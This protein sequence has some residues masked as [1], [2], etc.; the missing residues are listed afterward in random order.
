MQDNCCPIRI[1]TTQHEFENILGKK[2]RRDS[3]Q[4]AVEGY[5]ALL[6]KRNQAAPGLGGGKVG[7]NC[8]S[9]NF[10]GPTVFR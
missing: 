3:A 8:E 10:D 9:C 6:N 2:K 5:N 7:S 4:F 1:I